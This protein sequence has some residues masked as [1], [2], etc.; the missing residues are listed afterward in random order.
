V[1]DL[2]D[3][4]ALL[5]SGVSKQLLVNSAKQQWHLP[6][7]FIWKD[8]L[9]PYESVSTEDD[10]SASGLNNLCG[11]RL[12]ELEELCNFYSSDSSS[13]SKGKYYSFAM[14]PT[15]SV[16]VAQETLTDTFPVPAQSIPTCK[17]CGITFPEGLL[18]LL[19]YSCTFFD[20]ESW[21][22]WESR[23]ADW[24][25]TDPLPES[26]SWQPFETIGQLAPSARI[27]VNI[28][29][30]CLRYVTSNT[31]IDYGDC[32]QENVHAENKTP[33][34]AQASAG[35][36]PQ[37]RRTFDGGDED[38]LQEEPNKFTSSRP[39]VS[40]GRDDLRFLQTRTRCTYLSISAV[41]LTRIAAALQ[42]W[43]TSATQLVSFRASLL[44]SPT[45][46]GTAL[47]V[48]AQSS[49]RLLP[50]I[51]GRDFVPF[52]FRLKVT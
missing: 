47:N 6:A 30:T 41:L 49:G 29:N 19:C 39:V 34:P 14:S 28:G 36:V 43:K 42:T 8:S 52:W 1:I 31:V 9:I 13:G 15:V 33:Q 10:P 2:A 4:L 51:K 20:W 25:L 17:K 7:A 45:E 48:S 24:S 11:G 38:N 12:K 22:S 18:D 21:E 27:Q 16:T 23:N 37:T 40:S 35:C 50:G 32:I 26:S 5:E 44:D 3:G 46:Q